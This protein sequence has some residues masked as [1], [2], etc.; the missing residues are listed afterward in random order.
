MI[1]EIE[2]TVI[3]YCVH[4]KE[5]IRLLNSFK[6][7]TLNIKE[8]LEC[9]DIPLLD[10]YLKERN[11]II[12]KIEQVDKKLNRI[13]GIAGFSMGKLS[14]EAKSLL[15]GYFDQIR[16]LLESLSDVDRDCL[17]LARVEYDCIKSEILKT[18]QGRHTVTQY[19]PKSGQSAR[20][21]DIKRV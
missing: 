17:S 16:T 11:G 9:R 5:K 14:R 18:Q 21:L 12:G 8:A 20:L 6:K 2:E 15:G 1:M 10:H 7:A 4:L 19:R 3:K 13:I